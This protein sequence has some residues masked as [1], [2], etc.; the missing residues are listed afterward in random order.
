[1]FKGLTCNHTCPHYTT[2]EYVDDIDDP[3]IVIIGEVIYGCNL[4]IMDMLL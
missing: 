1:M 4:I 3:S 2:W